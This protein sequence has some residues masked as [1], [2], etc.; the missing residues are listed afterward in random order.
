MR[1]IPGMRKVTTAWEE[2]AG[3]GKG[4]MSDTGE[5]GLSFILQQR[6]L[7]QMPEGSIQGITPQQSDG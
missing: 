5:S 3:E 4:E 1:H 7:S 2:P 6:G